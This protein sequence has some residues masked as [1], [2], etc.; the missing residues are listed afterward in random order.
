MTRV[1]PALGLVV[2]SLVLLASTRDA[3][4]KERPDRIEVLEVIG[5]GLTEEPRADFESD[6]QVRCV[7][8][9]IV[10][11]LGIAR[12]E[13]LGLDAERR[14][15]PRL[16]EPGLTPDDRN[17]VF[18]AYDSCLDATQDQIE[19]YVAEGLSESEA[20]CI[21]ASYRA[22]GIARV[23]LTEAPHGESLI[24]TPEARAHLDE[25]LEA[26]EAAC[27]DWL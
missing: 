23:H 15:A 5:V 27:R 26:A 17:R 2:L 9:R 20:R 19:G 21:A 12:L 10:K 22:S 3:V 8:R 1:H 4:A 7:A 24:D 14:V 18:A 13:A 6:R 11:K 25:F 16:Y